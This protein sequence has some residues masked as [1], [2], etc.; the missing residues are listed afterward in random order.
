MLK[1]NPFVPP[2]GCPVNSL[3]DEL[4]AYIFTVGVQLQE[5]EEEDDDDDD[6]EEELLMQ[7]DGDDEWEDE[8]DVEGRPS[9]SKK[10]STAPKDSEKA[11]GEET[12]TDSST[13]SED[14]S[15]DDDDE[16]PVMPFQVLV[17]HVCQRWRQVALDT[18][19]L[20][21]VLFP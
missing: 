18:P 7:D 6:E 9:R 4:L 1:N 17:S 10:K 15:E 2:E 13:D 21:C 5:E 11:D 14:D 19:D 8:E 12:Q 20:W 3:P 16:G